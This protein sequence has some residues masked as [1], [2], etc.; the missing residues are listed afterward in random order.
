MSIYEK[1]VLPDNGEDAISLRPVDKAGYEDWFR[2]QPDF[3]RQSLSAQKFE[4]GSDARVLVEAANVDPSPEF[5]PAVTGCQVVKDLFER[6]AMQGIVGLGHGR[7]KYSRLSVRQSLAP[8][9]KSRQ[10]P[11]RRS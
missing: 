5:R 10:T 7:V 4:A 8:V 1:L 6:D 9:A 11:G 2:A 3:V